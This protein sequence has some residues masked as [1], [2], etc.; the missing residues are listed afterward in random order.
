MKSY[1]IKAAP[2]FGRIGSGADQYFFRSRKLN[3]PAWA[4]TGIWRHDSKQPLYKL[5]RI[6]R[7]VS[8]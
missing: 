7:S 2:M 5:Q 1:A 8:L 4:K 6:I 3:L